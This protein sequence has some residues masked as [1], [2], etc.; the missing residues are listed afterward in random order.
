V[1]FYSL[2][3]YDAARDE[4]PALALW[5]RTWQQT[6]PEIDFAARLAW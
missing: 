5:L 3:Q 1:S 4:E 2:R 6:Y